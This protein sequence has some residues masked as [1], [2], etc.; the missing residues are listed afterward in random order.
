M[1]SVTTQDAVDL[2]VTAIICGATVNAAADFMVGFMKS[3]RLPP[4]D[5]LP[6]PVPLRPWKPYT[7]RYDPA[8]WTPRLPEKEWLP[9]CGK[10]YQRDGYI[11]A[12]CDDEEGPFQIDHVIPVTRGGSNEMSNLRVACRSCN[13]SKGD[14]L[15]SEWSWRR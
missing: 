9:L 10:V 12:Y 4:Y 7:P 1:D 13:S 2:L 11:C 6:M 3:E 15:L 5:Q 8:G 14:R